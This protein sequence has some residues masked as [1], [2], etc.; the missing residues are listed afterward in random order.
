MSFVELALRGE[1]LC[2][3]VP[4]VDILENFKSDGAFFD[5]LENRWF[6]INIDYVN[7]KPC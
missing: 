4:R 1:Q 7:G 3:K 2:K 6:W 5:E